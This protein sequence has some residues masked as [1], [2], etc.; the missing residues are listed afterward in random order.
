MPLAE[1]GDTDPHWAKCGCTATMP[2]CQ[3]ARLRYQLDRNGDE[4]KTIYRQRTADERVSSQAL[5]LGVERPKLRNGAA[6][7]NQNTLIYVLIN[8]R[9]LQRVR[10]HKAEL[11]RQEAPVTGR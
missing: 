3:G 8:V 6:I 2:T 1:R 4:Y 9:A 11:A 7:T 5:E 10:A